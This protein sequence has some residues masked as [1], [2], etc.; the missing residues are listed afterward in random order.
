MKLSEMHLRDPFIL[1][2][3]GKY[4]L[5]FSPG[6]YSWEGCDGFYCTVS[7]NLEN[8]SEPKKCF[9]QPKGFWAT[10]NFW[11]PEV[12][13]Y[14]GKFYLFASFFAQGHMRAVQVMA[15]D[16]P[17]G[18]F[19]VWSCP[20]TPNN[21]MCLDGTLFIE[22]DKPYMI[23]CHE[24]LQTY[25][26]EICAVEL[27]PDLKEPVG[28]IKLLFKAS[29]SEWSSNKDV[30][31]YIT[32]GPFIYKT[33]D[34]KLIMTWSSLDES[35]YAVGVAYSENGSLFGKWKHCKKPLSDIDGGHGMIFK[36]F[37]NKTYFTMHYRE[38][39][40]N[41]EHPCLIL[42]NEIPEEPFIKIEKVIK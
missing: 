13:C 32:D 25:D 33:A 22:D 31:G 42:F 1:P 19:E 15:S 8:W 7:E 34:G 37:D 4:Y 6:K 39:N 16:K 9:D 29:E 38:D 12:H 40:D 26:G 10:N 28:E 24:W 21:W 18:P 35:R 36:G 17:D 30:N 3:E 20:L 14:N 41:I 23:F 5:Y 27:S 2:Y 11:A